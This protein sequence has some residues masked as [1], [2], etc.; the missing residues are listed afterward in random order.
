MMDNVIHHSF[1]FEER[2]VYNRYMTTINTPDDLI[3]LVREDDAFR[4]A[5]RRELLTAEILETPQRLANLERQVAELVEITKAINARL[6]RMDQTI[7]AIIEQTNAINRRLDGIE[8]DVAE[9]KSDITEMKGDISVIKRDING[10]GESAQAGSAG[11]IQLPRQLR[12]E[13]R[14]RIR[15]RYCLSVRA[16]AWL[17]RCRYHAC[18]QKHSIEVAQ[19]E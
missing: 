7:A 9:T 6:D 4:E 19:R 16:Q 11:A 8:A 18:T 5:M 14:V 17:G 13:R 2:M 15:S 3:R 1:L 12:P 10:L